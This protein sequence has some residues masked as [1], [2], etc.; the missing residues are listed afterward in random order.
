MATKS[1]PFAN[2][3][4]WTTSRF[5]GFLRSALRNASLRYPPRFTLLTTNRKPYKGPQKSRKWT[6]TCANCQGEFQGKEVEIDHIVPVGTLKSFD[7]LP[8]FVERLFCAED[9]LQLLC[10]GCHKDKTHAKETPE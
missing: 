4:A 8:Q 5:F 1:P 6:Y 3:P 9:G 7:D 2:Y 10:K